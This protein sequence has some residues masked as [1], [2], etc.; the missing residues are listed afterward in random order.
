M[1]HQLGD[2]RRRIEALAASGGAFRLAC[3]RAGE[4]SVPAADLRFDDRTQ[5]FSEHPH[6]A[7]SADRV[8]IC[9]P[10]YTFDRYGNVVLGSTKIVF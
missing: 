1:I 5:S 7:A 3:A 4:R 2:L 10:E 8:Y 6:V 9:P